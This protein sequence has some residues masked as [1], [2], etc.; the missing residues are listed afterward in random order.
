MLKMFPV[1]VGAAML[2]ASV[3][4]ANAEELRLTDDQMDQVTA[5]GSGYGYYHRYAIAGA[6]AFADAKAFSRRGSTVAFTYTDTFAEAVR[7]KRYS[8]AYAYSV[9]SSYAEAN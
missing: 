6:D 9:S 5:A 8:A 4:V 1:L 2:T 7:K 3:A